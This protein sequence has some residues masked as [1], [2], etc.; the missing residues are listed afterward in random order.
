MLGNVLVLFFVHVI[1][2]LMIVACIQESQVAQ[3]PVRIAFC[4]GSSKSRTERSK[5]Q[6]HNC[7]Q[8]LASAFLDCVSIQSLL[9]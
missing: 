9:Y 7:D 8:V 5:L 2:V 4:R 6:I 3:E 1:T